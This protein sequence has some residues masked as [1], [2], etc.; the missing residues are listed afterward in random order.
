[1]PSGGHE[2]SRLYADTLY[3]F[4]IS[5]VRGIGINPVVPDHHEVSNPVSVPSNLPLLPA[6]MKNWVLRFEP[7][8][9]SLALVSISTKS[10]HL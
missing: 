9:A 7:N 2:Y 4:G 10:V 3:L 5:V 6:F 1:M 8:E